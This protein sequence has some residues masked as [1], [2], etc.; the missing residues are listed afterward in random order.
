VIIVR[1]DAN[2]GSYGAQ[3]LDGKEKTDA[4]KHYGFFET[5][6]G[7]HATCETSSLCRGDFEGEGDEGHQSN[8]GEWGE[9]GQYEGKG[10]GC[11]KRRSCDV[12]WPGDISMLRAATMAWTRRFEGSRTVEQ[13][14]AG[15]HDACR[16]STP[17]PPDCPLTLS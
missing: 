14:E 3:K 2:E 8:D 9:D 1:N 4:E 16:A 12:A 6:G 17:L 7:A 11:G 15:H 13:Q 5:K 10:E